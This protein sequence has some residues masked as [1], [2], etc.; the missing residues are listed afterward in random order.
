MSQGQNYSRNSGKVP[1]YMLSC[2]SPRTVVR[3]TLNGIC[4]LCIYQQLKSAIDI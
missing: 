3:V 4:Y 1:V 2:P